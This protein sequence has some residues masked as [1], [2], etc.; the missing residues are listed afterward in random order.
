M[1][2]SFSTRNHPYSETLTRETPVWASTN[3]LR[4]APPV[5]FS[6]EAGEFTINVS[7]SL[8]NDLSPHFTDTCPAGAGRKRLGK[9]G[10]SLSTQDVQCITNIAQPG[11]TYAAN[12][13]Q[14]SLL[15]FP[16]GL[17]SLKGPLVAAINSLAVFIQNPPLFSPTLFSGALIHTIL[18]VFTGMAFTIWWNGLG[19]DI[20]QNTLPYPDLEDGVSGIVSG[21]PSLT[22]SW[23]SPTQSTTVVV[24]ATNPYTIIRV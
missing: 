21:C 15:L 7:Q 8:A 14:D 1:M 18:A 23:T 11:L 20:T 4:S 3:L 2:W 13:L 6:F 22:F 5:S 16:T 9:R 24:S 17:P 12:N 10:L 19:T